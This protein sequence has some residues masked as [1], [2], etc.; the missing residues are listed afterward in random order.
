MLQETFP[1]YKDD[2]RY[3]N[4][5]EKMYDLVDACEPHEVLSWMEVFIEG[6]YKN[7]DNYAMLAAYDIYCKVKDEYEN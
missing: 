5:Q 4:Y 2:R 3:K 6:A 1:K 7:M